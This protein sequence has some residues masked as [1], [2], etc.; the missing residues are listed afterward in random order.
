MVH[1]DD[2]ERVLAESNRTNESGEDYDIEHRIVRKDGRV[3]WVRDHAFLVRSGESEAWQGVLT[4]VTDRKLAEEALSTRD[5]ILQAAGYA[6]ERFLRAPSWR[7]CIDDVLAHLGEAGAATRAVVFE[8]VESASGMHVTMRHAWLADD[9]PAQLER[10]PSPPLPYGERYA[11]WIDVLGEG[12]VIHGP[13]NSLPEDE[14]SIIQEAGI[15]S[16]I[17]VP[18]HV[19]GSWWGYIGFDDCRSDRV[20]QPAEIDAI[21]VIANTLSAA[22]ERELHARLLTEAEER[23]RAIVEHVPAAIYLDRA[24]RSMHSIYISPQ[25]EE[26]T[27]ITQQE[28]LDDP[29]LWLSI[30]LPEDREEAQ[31]TYIEAVSARR[32]W[33]S[34]YRVNTRDGRVIWLHDETTLVTG[35]DGEPLFLQGV[36]M[37]ITERK[38]SEEAL[39]ESERREREAAERLRALDEMKNTFLAAV[40]HELRSPL[41]SIL[42]LSITLERA[43]EMATDDR[44]DLLERLAFNARKLDKLLKDLLDIDRLNRGIVEPQYRTVDVAALT[45]RSVESLDTLNGRSVLFETNPL[46]LTIDPPKLERIVE[47]LVTNAVRHTPDTSRIW[48]RLESVD[49]GALLSVE[50]EGPGVPIE[51]RTAVFEP[52][53]QGPTASAHSPGTGVGLSLVASFAELHGGR[54]WVDERVGGGAAF[55][56]FLPAAAG[57]GPSGSSNA[58]GGGGR[59]SRDDGLSPPAS[60]DA[61]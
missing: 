30:M 25:I 33:K 9:A 56:V 46:V 38:L 61:I 20:W 59:A 45:R 6:A 43:P 18:V 1:P 28:W 14:R 49:G 39:R 31:R 4:D 12:G 44:V 26:L 58:N 7:E 27:G 51:L 34:E 19:G 29:E 21:R 22:I 52:F 42:G 55:R 2:R 8:N 48:V 36:L 60:A 37:D 53:R 3:I 5:R 40:S 35:A 50:D 54:A 15:R 13:V 47:N 41:T 16:T 17:I 23:Y 11:R 24:D 57:T 10:P 32:P